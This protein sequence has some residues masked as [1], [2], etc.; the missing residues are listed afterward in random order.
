M[1][2]NIDDLHNAMLYLTENKL[3]Q[4]MF[5]FNVFNIPKVMIDQ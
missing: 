4:Y 1:K 3:Y 2:G 5:S